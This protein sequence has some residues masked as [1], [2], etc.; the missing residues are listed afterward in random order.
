MPELIVVALPNTGTTRDRDYT[1]PNDAEDRQ[2]LSGRDQ[3]IEFI[4]VDL[5]LH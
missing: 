2:Q 1:P 5:L 3:F 4:E